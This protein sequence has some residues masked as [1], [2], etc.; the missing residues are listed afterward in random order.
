MRDIDYKDKGGIL[1]PLKNISFFAGK[2]VTVPLDP[3]PASA[4]Y[5]GFHLN[6]WETCIGCSTCQKVCDNAAIT[7]I[8]VPGLPEDPEK[9]VRNLRPAIDYGRCCWCALC[10]DLCPT[11]SISLSR[12]YVHTCLD[13]EL[14]SYFILPDSKGIH[15]KYFGHGW[16]K[17]DDADLVALEREPMEE[18]PPASRIENFDEIVTGYTDNQAIIE[19]S[20]CVQCGMCHDACPT[21]MHAPEYIRALWKGDPEEA[22]R[23]IYRTNPF[24]HTCGRICTHRCETACSVGHRGTPIAIRWLKRYAMDK[25]G[26]ERVKEIAAEGKASYITGKRVAIVGAGPAGL[27]AAFDLVRQGHEVTVYEAQAEPG[28]MTRY[29]I[30]YYRLPAG[31]LDRDVDVIAS[32]GVKIQYNTR[33]GTDISMEEMRQGFDAVLLSIGLWMGRSTRVPG[34]DHEGVYRAVDLLRSVAAGDSVPVP[35][36]TVVIGGGNVAM[37]IARTM[38]RL[39]KQR[40]GE[41]RVTLTALEDRAHFLADPDEVEESLE[42]GIAILDARGP[43]QVLVGDARVEGLRTWKVLSI[44]DEKGRFSPSFDEADEQVHEGEMIIEAIGQGANVE[45][46][47][48]ALKEQ[49][50]WSRG[51]LKVDESGRTSEPWL[52][53]AGDMVRGPDVVSAVADGHRVAASISEFLSV[54]EQAA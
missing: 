22:V 34:S 14:G 2:P 50:E 46:L 7:M 33:V 24:A 52:W 42:E 39:Q 29:G 13:S 10:V 15:G 40:Y 37:D 12:E 1:N 11:G 26:H 35:E 3:R 17:S 18:A 30:P 4:N 19:A 41:V 36:T 28:G 31:M 44:F 32:L 20:R 53:A 45:L 8:R 9:G 43:Q 27:T 48:E 16:A 51:R 23:E 49:L 5:R 25:V 54:K 38:A 6:D 47:G 21:H